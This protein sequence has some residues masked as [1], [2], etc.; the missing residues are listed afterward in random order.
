MTPQ[1]V[2]GIKK[3]E[4]SMSQ[5]EKNAA[6]EGSKDKINLGGTYSSVSGLSTTKNFGLRSGGFINNTILEEVSH[7][8][9]SKSSSK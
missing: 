8:G 1:S 4:F 9:T 5:E 2:R 3:I 7:S 6:L